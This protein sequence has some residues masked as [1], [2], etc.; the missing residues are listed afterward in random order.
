MAKVENTGDPFGI[1]LYGKAL[2]KAV[3]EVSKFLDA[4]CLPAAERFGLLLRDRV[5][6]WRL[7]NTIAIMKETKR[8]LE[9]RGGTEGL[10]VH[11]R[12]IM[13]VFDEGSFVEDTEVQKMWA[14][15]LASSCTKNNKN[16]I[17]LIFLNILTNITTSQARIINLAFKKD[18][19]LY[20]KY[21]NLYY[22]VI[23]KETSKLLQQA[24]LPNSGMLLCVLDHLGSLGLLSYH[25]SGHVQRQFVHICFEDS[26]LQLYAR[27]HGHSGTLDEFLALQSQSENVKK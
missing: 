8:L 18:Y 3:E 20:K 26:A 10:V 4:L 6:L 21:P 1:R 17:N 13:K 11:P 19:K 14:G 2:A 12:I 22:T 9:D 7:K 24:D 25:L 15:L 27:C 5:E 16:D 23:D